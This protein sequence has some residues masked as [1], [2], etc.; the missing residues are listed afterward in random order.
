MK[1][2]HWPKSNLYIILLTFLALVAFEP[3]FCQENYLPGYI[4]S[5]HG[6]TVAG[7]VDYRNWERNPEKIY[8]RESQDGSKSTF[9]P[10]DIKGFGVTDEV[11]ESAIVETETSTVSTQYL[12]YSSELIFKKDTAFLQAVVKGAKSLY[13]YKDRSGKEQFYIGQDSSYELLIYKRYLK[14]NEG[15]AVIAENKK[16]IG[17]LTIYLHDCPSI[18]KK[19]NTADYRVNSLENVFLSYYDCI[20]AGMTFH[21]KTEKVTTAIGVLAGVSLTSL[22]LRSSD[23]YFSYLVNAN[24]DLS[25]NFSGGLYFDVI[26]PRNQGKWSICNELIWSSYKVNGQVDDFVNENKYTITYTTLGYS[27]L[28]M[29]NMVRF[30]YPVGK[31]SLFINAGIS[32]GYAII[33]INQKKQE[34]KLYTQIRIEEGK[35]LSDSRRYELGVVAGVGAAIGRFSFEARYERGNGMS[36]YSALNSSTNRI[37]FLLGFRF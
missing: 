27:Y 9:T 33:E 10:L 25:V 24:Y 20:R 26:L 23:P 8:F 21:K 15:Q 32:N 4:L 6:D 17:Q 2:P 30:R 22:T 31:L 13:F 3:A 28:K 19:L 12:S 18:Q 14:D 37:Y 5:L 34:S 16:F 11:Y 29:N 36:T 35:A 7:Y 1:N